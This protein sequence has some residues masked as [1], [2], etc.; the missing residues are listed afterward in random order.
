LAERNNADET[1]LAAAKALDAHNRQQNAVVVDR[2]VMLM[3]MLM[4]MMMMIMMMMM[5]IMMMMMLLFVDRLF[6]HIYSYLEQIKERIAQRVEAVPA[7]DTKK[8]TS[9]VGTFCVVRFLFVL[10]NCNV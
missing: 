8:M 6:L 5:M 9:I 2:F 10:L 1:A 4:M 3:M 7:T